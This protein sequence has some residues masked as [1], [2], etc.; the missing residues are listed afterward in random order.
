[1]LHAENLLEWP[2]LES[3][4]AT[5]APSL[6]RGE[7]HLD[8]Y[9]A[10]SRKEDLD[11]WRNEL[12]SITKTEA[13]CSAPMAF[14]AGILYR[15]GIAIQWTAVGFTID[16]ESDDAIQRWVSV[17]EMTPPSSR[18]NVRS[19]YNIATAW[20]NAYRLNQNPGLLDNAVNLLG[21]CLD[22]V[23]ADSPEVALCWEGKSLA[24]EQR[25]LRFG[26]PP[27]L[28]LS[29]AAAEACVQLMGESSLAVRYLA[30]LA[31]VCQSR[32]HQRGRA[33]RSRPCSRPI[34][35]GR[36]ETGRRKS[37]MARFPR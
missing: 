35:Y 23:E 13:Y 16:A 4:P 8:A 34:R 24:L 15:L 5:L 22:S 3:S 6:R 2:P 31:S 9:Y 36:V 26:D 7:I 11:A 30:R 37:G 20:V 10:T 27:D 12:Q 21:E 19:K 28:D 29:L 25:Y 17:I 32:Y 1:M 14:K 18:L 33:G